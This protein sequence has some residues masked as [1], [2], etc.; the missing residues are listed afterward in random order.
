MTNVILVS[1]EYET[2]GETNYLTKYS[3]DENDVWNLC[4]R[5]VNMNLGDLPQSEIINNFNEIVELG[6]NEF[7]E[8]EK[9]ERNKTINAAYQQYKNLLKICS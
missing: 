6:I 4:V 2:V 3:H 5:F 8:K 1:Y 9:R 7:E